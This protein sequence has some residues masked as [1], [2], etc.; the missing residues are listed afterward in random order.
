MS[1]SEGSDGEASAD[2]LAH[3]VEVGGDPEDLLSPS[4]SEAEAGHDLVEDEEGAMFRTELPDRL[5]IAGLREVEPRV[6]RDGFENDTGDLFTFVLKEGLEG[7]HIIE[8]D[9]GSECS[10]GTGNPGAVGLAEG[11]GA[12]SGLHQQGVDMAVVAAFEL[13]DP[14]A[15]GKA[16]GKT[17]R[18]HDGLGAAI[19]HPHFFDRGDHPA[20]GLGHLD[21]EGVGDPEAG[22]VPGSLGHGIDHDLR[23]MTQNGRAPCA[24]KVDVVAAVGIGDGAPLGLGD[25]EGFAAH[26]AEGADGGVHTTGNAAERT[27]PQG[28]GGGRR[29]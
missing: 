18:R 2:D 26:A 9:G 16:P 27:I 13:H 11:E 5:Q 21:L 8:G 12:A 1:A 17:D 25:E 7:L 29:L 14:F 28:V 20:D 15:S 10:Q 6:R 23:R 19:G 22:A 4:R 3:R 24:D